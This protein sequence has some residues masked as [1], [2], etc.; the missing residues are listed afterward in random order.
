MFGHFCGLYGDLVFV[1]LRHHYRVVLFLFHSVTTTELPCLTLVFCDLVCVH[2]ESTMAQQL[3]LGQL[4][5]ESCQRQLFPLRQLLPNLRVWRGLP[6]S[7]PS[8]VGGLLFSFPSIPHFV[9]SSL[10]S[11]LCP[12][13]HSR[14]FSGVANAR[15]P[16]TI[17]L[18]FDPTNQW[19]SCVYND[20][21]IYV[22]DVRDPKKVGKV[23]SALYHS[24]C[25]WSVEVGGLTRD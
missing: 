4:L 25:V 8:F 16:D 3:V 6:C 14:L 12:L 24:S 2:Q 21:S 22:W 19:L 15:Y 23:Y 11:L 1:C 9:S 5:A 10:T 7:A 17:A 13:P 20:H 18:T